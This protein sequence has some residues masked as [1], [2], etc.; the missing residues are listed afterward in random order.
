MVPAEKERKEEEDHV[1]VIT[2]CRENLAKIPGQNSAANME[3]RRRNSITEL[4]LGKTKKSEV[5]RNCQRWYQPYPH[6]KLSAENNMLEL[7]KEGQIL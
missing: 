5:V 4:Q 3:D 7:Q 6:Q 1:E 2:K